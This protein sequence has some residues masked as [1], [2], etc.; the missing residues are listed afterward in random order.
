[1][2]KKPRAAVT[3]LELLIAIILISVILATVAGGYLFVYGR[4]I[5]NIRVQNVH[6]QM[7]YALEN[8]RLHCL[9]AVRVEDESLFTAGLDGTK[10]SFSFEG[11]SDIHNITP[12]N[13]TDNTVYTYCLDESKNLVLK[14]SPD[15]KEV[16]IDAQYSPHITFQY[17]EGAEPNFLTVTVTAATL[18][19]NVSKTEGLRFWFT[20]VVGSS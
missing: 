5:E 3:L 16:L 8:I 4:L 1:M 9:S 11:E 12:D 17:Y 15:R 7:D 19:G 2:N 18:E 10:D 14:Y 20:D 13:S 6:L